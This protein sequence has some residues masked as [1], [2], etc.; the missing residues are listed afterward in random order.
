MARIL[1]TGAHGFIGKH[2]AQFLATS[3]HQVCGLG[4]GIW[5]DSESAAWGLVQWINGDIVPSNLRQLQQSIGTPDIVYHLAGGSSV[6]VAVAN[7]R[8]DFFRTVVTT[9]ELLD[10][11]R[12]DAPK[13]K[14]VAVSSAA[15]YG[16]GHSGRIEEQAALS[17]Y[18]PYGHHKRLMEELCRSYAASYG[19]QVAIARLFS[20]Y[21]SG[22][23]KQLLWDLCTRLSAG[24]NPLTL[25]GTG[26]ELRDWTDVRDVVRALA[27]LA[28]TASSVVPV[29]NVGTG[30]AVPVRE[31]ATLL[32]RHWA[33]TLGPASLSFSG[34]SRKGDPFSLVADPSGM[35]ALE[36][37]W[38]VGLDQ[39]LADYVEWFRKHEAV[40][41]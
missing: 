15:V 2:L 22:L 3:G 21:G 10:W 40:L 34:Q 23:K 33:G 9:A 6:G 35:T 32:A 39:G 4:H 31:V 24:A 19:T 8:E 7:P 25:G 17:P 12:L 16:A 29:F 11:L 18:S 37:E 14:L 5:P 28:N 13:A 20:V 26:E 36:F 38:R 1:I 41:Q 30:N 27:L